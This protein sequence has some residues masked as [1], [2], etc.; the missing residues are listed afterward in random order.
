MTFHTHHGPANDCIVR[1]LSEMA[2]GGFSSA[3]FRRRLIQC[4][5]RGCLV[6]NL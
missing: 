2:G 4:E 1:D 6:Y 5:Y 3:R